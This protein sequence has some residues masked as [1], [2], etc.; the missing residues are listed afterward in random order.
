MRK[1]IAAL[2][3]GSCIGMARIDPFFLPDE[4]ISS[5]SSS[6]ATIVAPLASQKLQ[7][8][9][10]SVAT[11][12]LHLDYG[13][14]KVALFDN[15]IEIT[16]KD[17]LKKHFLITHP[18]KIV[19][20]FYAKR[21]FASKKR[22]LHHPKFTELSLGAHKRFYRLAIAYKG[23]CKNRLKKEHSKVVLLCE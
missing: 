21:G 4:E 22:K 20:D 6:I 17:R 13:F 19:F 16:T 14:L 10:S 2:V 15:R 11:A 18:K 9:S 23:R 3:I 8:A 5:S 7:A 12:A 1:K